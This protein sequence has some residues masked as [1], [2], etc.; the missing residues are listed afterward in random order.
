M[1]QNLP[2]I[3]GLLLALAIPA[4]ARW[5]QTGS[6]DRPLRRIA[7]MLAADSKGKIKPDVVLT[8]PPEAPALPSQAVRREH[9]SILSAE[10]AKSKAFAG[11]GE[12]TALIE[13]GIEAA[14]VRAAD[15]MQSAF[16][17]L[18]A[19]GEGAP[20]EGAPAAPAAVTPEG[21]EPLVVP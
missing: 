11:P 20:A 9:D 8:P 6:G 14:N 7:R 18:T 1:K 21:A 3:L 4:E 13:V 15:L 17:T 16:E 12:L 10:A 19:P 5:F 2:L